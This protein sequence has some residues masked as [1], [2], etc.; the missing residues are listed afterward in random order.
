MMKRILKLLLLV[1]VGVSSPAWAEW[2]DK[3]I[4]VVVPY[5]PGAMPDVLIRLLS[6][7][8][9]N[10][11]GQPLVIE[12][13]SG[14]EGT[15]GAMAAARAAPDGYTLLVGGTS[16]FS[17][18]PSLHRHVDVDPLKAFDPI[19]IMGNVPAV[20]F[21]N[22]SVPAKTF[23]EF[24]AYAKANPGKLNYG[25]PGPAIRLPIEQINRSRDL[26]MV[27]VAYRGAG[28]VMMAVVANEVQFTLAGAGIGL[29]Q[30]K[31]GKIRALGVSS[32]SRLALLPDTPTFD[33]IGLKDV[34]VDTF[35]GVAA[36]AG[37]PVPILERL[38]AALRKALA[39]PRI[40]ERLAELGVIRVGGSR[41]QM[42][43]RA[44]NDAGEWSRL[45]KELGARTD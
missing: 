13:R 14:A 30:V 39:A 8:V 41:Q 44:T 34:H 11:L 15:V 35:W 38:N 6:E 12:N 43:E 5:G 37:T 32:P 21:V 33:E 9:G 40:K 26:R 20:I 24:V 3:P 42:A 27:H 16:I 29:Q 10:Q 18:N 36:P 19:T 1:V 22:A 28:Q 2:P 23:A 25:A 7:E 45:I 31:A 4:R 17:I